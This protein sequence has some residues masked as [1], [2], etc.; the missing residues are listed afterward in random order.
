MAAE[1]AADVWTSQQLPNGAGACA[2]GQ[3]AGGGKG[4]GGGAL[5]TATVGAHREE[6]QQQQTSP[7]GHAVLGGGGDS[8]SN[9]DV[10]ARAA[11]ALFLTGKVPPGTETSGYRFDSNEW[12]AEVKQQRNATWEWLKGVGSKVFEGVNLTRISLPVRLFEGRSYL[13]RI[14]DNWVYLE[15]LERAVR[16]RDPVQ[17]LRLVV[18]FG[19]SGL[20]RQVSF[21]KPFNPILGETVN[22]EYDNGFSLACEQL[23]HH[24]PVSA[25]HLVPNDGSF[26][27]SGWAGWSGKVYANS[28]KGFQMGVATLRCHATD[29][30][31][32]TW[33]L[34]TVCLKNISFGVR[35][36]TYEGVMTFRDEANR[37]TCHLCVGN[38]E[39][40]EGEGGADRAGGKR[41][42]FWKRLGGSSKEKLS[43]DALTGRIVCDDN[44][45]V[46]LATFDGNWIT[47]L[48]CD[49]ER[50]W[51]PTMHCVRATSFERKLPSD[52]SLRPDCQ[53]VAA[54]D[55]PRAQKA[56]EILEN[57]QRADAKLRK[58]ALKAQEKLQKLNRR[59]SRK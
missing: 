19:A 47:H 29:G 24:P 5:H 18:A 36:L 45:G 16:E 26:E 11:D 9:A 39:P 12:V 32:I 28:V 51:T 25:Y 13:E 33:N 17:R 10:A 21:A 55:W 57:K 38:D 56:K 49:G 35:V 48:D 4:E 2:Q 15:L 54:R 22:A 44:P 52:A 37:L 6:Q 23:S 1:H 14:R 58:E 31:A 20:C 30:A 7:S 53:A 59:N 27:F 40:A 8:S 42:G 34:P 43:P 41:G 3:G 46:A 50:L